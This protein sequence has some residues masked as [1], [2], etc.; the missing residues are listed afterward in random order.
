MTKKHF[1]ELACLI[2][3]RQKNNFS[4]EWLERELVKFCE[5]MN[6]RF[7]YR[8]FELFVNEIVTG[9]RDLTGKKI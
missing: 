9:R 5:Q 8:K 2:G 1:I 6:P 3:E 7:D 4:V